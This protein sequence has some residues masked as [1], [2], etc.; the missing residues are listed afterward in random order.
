MAT[1]VR[2]NGSSDETWLSLDGAIGRSQQED[3][4]VTGYLVELRA[5][6]E[7]AHRQGALGRRIGV[8]LRNTDDPDALAPW[9]DRLTLIAVE[10][11]RFT[12]GRG[13][14]IGRLLRA[15]LGFRGE[16]RAV[17]DIMRDQIYY[18]MRVGFDAFEL[19]ADQDG[20]AAH[21]ALRDFSVSYQ[22]SSDQ[23]LPHFRRY[24]A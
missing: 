12:D 10:F 6:I 23:A 18:L 16:L 5:W 7:G 24:A 3:A 4:G 15:R 8:L 2:Q 17:G 19:R 11:P 21:A 22:A 20:E 1:I 13:Y 9:L 14:S